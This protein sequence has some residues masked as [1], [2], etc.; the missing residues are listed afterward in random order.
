MQNCRDRIPPFPHQRSGSPQQQFGEFHRVLRTVQSVHDDAEFVSAEPRHGVL[1][2]NPGADPCR[3]LAQDEI[4][5]VMPETVVHR[6]ESIE[7]EIEQADDA[8]TFAAGSGAL[9]ACDR[10]LEVVEEKGSVGATGQRIVQRLVLENLL[11]AQSLRDVHRVRQNVRRASLGLG[12]PGVTIHERSL[13][14]RS[15]TKRDQPLTGSCF[16]QRIE[17]GRSASTEPLGNQ[18]DERGSD[19][20]RRR[21]AEGRR[22]R[23]VDGEERPLGGMC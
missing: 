2:A 6:F 1:L 13:F 17:G 14:T 21:V 3:G 18:I 4:A 7:I 22:A 9:S 20:F 10:A 16:R 19:Q 23:W 5:C 15:R 11:G 12:H 8:G